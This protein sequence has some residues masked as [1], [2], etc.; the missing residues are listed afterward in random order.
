ML[1]APYAFC[2]A[3]R[4]ALGYALVTYPYH[5]V[6]KGW[7]HMLLATCFQPY[8]YDIIIILLGLRYLLNTYILIVLLWH[9][10][11]SMLKEDAS[12]Q[13]IELLIEKNDLWALD[14][15]LQ[16][17]HDPSGVLISTWKTG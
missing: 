2:Y 9:S 4:Y 10:V 11:T 12:T 7:G 1:S 6:T 15:F 16:K 14:C 13:H 5:N 8:I 17:H 3:F